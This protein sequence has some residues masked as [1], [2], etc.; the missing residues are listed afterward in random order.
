[1]AVTEVTTNDI[2]DGAYRIIGVVSNDRNLSN[3]ETKQG[4]R[5]INQLLDHYSAEPNLIAYDDVISFPLVEGQESYTIS[6]QLPADVTN[7]RLVYLKYVNLIDNGRYR[8][9]VRVENDTMLYRYSRDE[10]YKRR[11]TIV[12]LQNEIGQSRIT[13]IQKPEKIYTCIIKGK[14]ILDHLEPTTIITQVPIAYH[15]FLEYA[16]ANE[17]RARIPGS[18]WS[19][20]AERNF[21]D[22]KTNL[23]STND[24]DIEIEPDNLFVIRGNDKL[25]PNAINVI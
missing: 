3:S 25:Q 5:V 7:K 2:L 8:Y 16:T 11:P 4:L 17:L 15:R 9:P 21:Q 20:E 1:M 23:T 13:F 24:M 18:R 6:D 14:F 19:Q 10:T 12:F 22:A